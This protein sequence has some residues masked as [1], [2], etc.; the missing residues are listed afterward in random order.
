MAPYIK[1]CVSWCPLHQAFHVTVL[2][3]ETYVEKFCFGFLKSFLKDSP[4][5][6][7]AGWKLNLIA[8]AQT[9]I[10]VHADKGPGLAAWT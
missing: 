5:T 7:H 4:F 10:W 8:E 2:A 1:D 6:L 3:S 9:A